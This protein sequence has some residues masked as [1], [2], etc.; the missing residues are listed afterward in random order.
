MNEG[1][2]TISTYCSLF[3]TMCTLGYYLSEYLTVH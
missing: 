1:K 2:R 3:T